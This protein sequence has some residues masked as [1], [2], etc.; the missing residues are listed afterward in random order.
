MAARN[1]MRKVTFVAVSLAELA[2]TVNVPF[3]PGFART[4]ASAI[5]LNALPSLEGKATIS[6]KIT[7]MSNDNCALSR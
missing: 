2:L 7:I 6:K 3:N 1:M 4:I 5:P